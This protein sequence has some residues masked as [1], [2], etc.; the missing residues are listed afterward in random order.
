MSLFIVVLLPI[1]FVAAAA[2]FEHQY[3]R[4]SLRSP[5]RVMP[6]IIAASLAIGLWIYSRYY[7]HSTAQSLLLGHTMAAISLVV[8]FS[9]FV[10]RYKSVLAAALVFLSGGL[11][12]ILWLLSRP[13]M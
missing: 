3:D 11:L 7:L 6:L 2:L 8:A 12:A 10:C 4:R 13:M 9:G 5:G 1:L